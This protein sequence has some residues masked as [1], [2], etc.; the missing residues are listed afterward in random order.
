MLLTYSNTSAQKKTY[1]T[2]QIIGEAPKID[3]HDL[4]RAWKQIDWES[5]FIATEPYDS[6][7]P[8][9]QTKFKLLYDENYLYIL[10][11]MLDSQP[12]SI[13][14]WLEKRDNST[15][16]NIS[17]R[18]DSYNDK[19][20]AFV[21]TITA[22][23]VIEDQ[24]ITNNVNWDI[25]WNAIWE[26]KTKIDSTGWWAELKIPFTQ[27]RFNNMKGQVW[28]MQVKRKLFRYE[29]ISSWQYRPA[30]S[31]TVVDYYGQ[32]IGLNYINSKKQLEV[33]PY[34]LIQNERYYPDNENVIAK[35]NTLTYNTGADAKIG[36][37]N[38]FT[39]DVTVNPDFGQ[40]E[41]DPSEVNL[42]V[43]ETFQNE[44]RTFFVE[45]NNILQKQLTPGTGSLSNDNI[46][47]SR[48]I[49]RSPQISLSTSDYDYVENPVGTRIL[50]AM[51]VSG[52]NKNG[53]SVGIL[54][55]ITR[56]EQG[57]YQLND[58]AHTVAVE[59]ATN[60]FVSSFSKDIN[61]GNSILSSIFTSTNRFIDSEDLHSL[62]KS[63][64]TGM[65]DYKQYL[66]DKTF[67]LTTTVFA[68]NINGNKE[69]MIETQSNSQHYLQR[70]DITHAKID[71]SIT[72]MNG[73]GGTISLEKGG[74]GNSVFNTWITWRSPSLELND[75]GYM[76]ESDHIQHILWYRYRILEP[77]SFYR[78]LYIDLNSWT[79]ADFMG[80]K[81]YN[82]YNIYYEFLLKNFFSLRNGFT[83]NTAGYS[84]SALRGGPRMR[85]EGNKEMY[86]G[87][88][89]DSKK[90]IFINSNL[91]L[92]QGFNS[93]Y[94][95]TDYNIEFKYRPLPAMT[96]SLV[97]KYNNYYAQDMFV[98]SEEINKQT[99]YIMGLI[100]QKTYAAEIRFSFILSA[101]MSIDYYGMP[102]LS[103][104]NYSKYKFLND[105]LAKHPDQRFVEFDQEHINYH[106]GSNTYSV[107]YNDQ[108]RISFNNPNYQIKEYKSNVVF[109]WEYKKGSYFYFVWSQFRN[110]YTNGTET[111][112]S[113]IDDIPTIYTISPKNTFVVKLS[114]LISR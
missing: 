92:Q 45:G 22:G 42:D 23:G 87:F 100:K 47:Y 25:N 16:D 72:T 69:S 44:R 108:T 4:D 14:T 93:Y 3:G 84:N 75:A 77:R 74:K 34:V 82:G 27:L 106:S 95:I 48:R 110:E 102:F 107:L 12:D 33:T 58:T 26:G 66:S 60:Y 52:K 53:L 9:F 103:T 88:S 86:L 83:I 67:L 113:K 68:S 111:F 114:Y 55:S 32:L 78:K 105:P 28:G 2:Q 98:T 85:Y 76:R 59:P 1:K 94:G 97:P 5:N 21:F 17:F 31:S 35:S 6:V 43:F 46:F 71:S 63:A 41:A 29:E 38:D 57:T 11:H 39:L 36:I 65:F 56:K 37:T 49:G 79:G 89:T 8:V 80:R 24:K 62:R 13:N 20:T 18:F 30:N 15:G 96:I 112:S 19:Q 50:S 54:E 81:K 91:F 101:K 70:P 10:A 64:Y 90:K 7:E 40:V 99:Y 73:W 51:K 104:G 61:Q 109:K